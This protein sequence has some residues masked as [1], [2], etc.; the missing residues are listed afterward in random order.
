[1]SRLDVALTE[2][3]LA[4][5]RSAAASL[6]KNGQV[7]VNGTAVTKPS[8]EVEDGDTVAVLDG[9]SGKYVS[10]GGLKLEKALSFFRVDPAGLTCCD[11]GASTGGF[12]DCLLKNG[13]KK[14]YAVDCGHGQLHPSLIGDGR[15]VSLEGVNAKALTCDTLG[16]KADL[17]V[18]DVSFISQVKL[19]PA[20]CSVLKPGGRFISLIKPQF[21]VGRSGIGKGGIVKND[22]IREKA[23]D[24]VIACAALHGLAC[25]GVTLSPIKGGD[26]NTEYLALFMKE[27]TH[28]EN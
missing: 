20:V 16:E 27:D 10:R 15:V 2:R 21:E 7:T 12:T 9:D 19:Y 22:K 18:M 17:C 4:P 8:H 11:I 24:D 5:S 25:K 14:V 1:M 23:K 6:I 26:G 28:D 13:A 3:K